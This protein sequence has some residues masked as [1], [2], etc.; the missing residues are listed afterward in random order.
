MHR[1]QSSEVN[2]SIDTRLV[3]CLCVILE[4]MHVP[5]QVLQYNNNVL[6]DK[7]VKVNCSST[8]TIKLCL[9]EKIFTVVF[10]CFLN[11]ETVPVLS[12]LKWLPCWTVQSWSKQC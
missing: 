5:V 10:V 4:I 6:C 12:S 8:K 7:T 11:L 2:Q 1:K 3:K 9:M